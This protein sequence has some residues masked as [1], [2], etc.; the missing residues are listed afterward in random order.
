MTVHL[1][2]DVGDLVL[3][4]LLLFIVVNLISCKVL[5]NLSDF[6]LKFTDPSISINFHPFVG[7]SLLGKFLLEALLQLCELLRMQLGGNG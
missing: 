3:E 4:S 1:G 5:S 6:G 7:R 2:I